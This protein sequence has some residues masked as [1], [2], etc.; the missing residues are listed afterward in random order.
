MMGWL[1][2]IAIGVVFFAGKKLTETDADKKAQQD[3]FASKMEKLAGILDKTGTIREGNALTSLGGS[4][5]DFCKANIVPADAGK[6]LSDD[7]KKNYCGCATVGMIKLYYTKLS[8][9][10]LIK[11]ANLPPP[12]DLGP[13]DVRDEVFSAC[14]ASLD[15][16]NSQ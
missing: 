13:A 15:A 7:D 10:E 2:A 16:Y 6:A 4:F 1:L 8:D 14:N 11:R 9:T 12:R 5:F 3:A